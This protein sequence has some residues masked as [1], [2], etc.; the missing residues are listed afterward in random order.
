[1]SPLAVVARQGQG[2][3]FGQ[4]VELPRQRPPETAV[5]QHRLRHVAPF[6]AGS[7]VPK[8]LVNIEWTERIGR[9]VPRKALCCK[10]EAGQGKALPQLPNIDVDNTVSLRQP[11]PGLVLG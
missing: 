3:Q 11:V 8:A 10:V 6:D 7:A 2:S 5:G 1:M 9:D 4:E